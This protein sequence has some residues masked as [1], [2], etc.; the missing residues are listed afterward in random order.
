MNKV[1]STAAVITALTAGTAFAG[2]LAEPIE[3]APVE[4]IEDT[5]GSSSNAGL[6]IP[7]ILLALIVAAMQDSGGSSPDRVIEGPIQ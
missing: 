5:A 4:I 1:V 2:G 7:L 3:M 6:I